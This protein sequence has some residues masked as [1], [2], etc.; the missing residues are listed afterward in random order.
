MVDWKHLYSNDILSMPDKLEYPWFASWDLAFHTVTLGLIDPQFAK[1]Q[2]LLLVMEWFM[3]PNGQIPAFEL[4]FSNKNPPVHAWAALKIYQQEQLIYG[5]AGDKEFL[6][7]IFDKLN[8]NFTWWI[9]RVD[10]EGRNIFGGGFLG[11]DNIRIMELSETENQPRIEQTD[12]TA[13]MAMFCLNMMKIANELGK[14]DL[15][16]KYLQHFIYICDA[17]N[18]KIGLWDEERGFG[19][20]LLIPGLVWRFIHWLVWFLCSPSKN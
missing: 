4:D 6:G 16:R 18:S 11:L 12:G 7:R 1:H 9:N 19:S 3:H 14:Y 13:W 8:L 2:L 17:I 15:E 20:K 10:A 5:E